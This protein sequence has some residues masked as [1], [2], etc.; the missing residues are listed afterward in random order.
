MAADSATTR[1][2]GKIFTRDFLLLAIINLAVFF[3]F[4]MVNVGLPLYMD[5]L[6]ATAS[7]TLA[8]DIIPRKRFAEGMG[9]FAMAQIKGR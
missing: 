4:Q 7:A 6:G 9:Y 1:S 2:L 5:Q 3:G 8:A